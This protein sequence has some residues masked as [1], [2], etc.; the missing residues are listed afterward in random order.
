[1]KEAGYTIRF[2]K[3]I[4]PAVP[5][6]ELLVVLLFL[7][8]FSLN[9]RKRLYKLVNKLLPECNMKAIF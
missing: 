9:L 8:I 2:T 5:K 6:R 3:H 1:M 7:G 4:V